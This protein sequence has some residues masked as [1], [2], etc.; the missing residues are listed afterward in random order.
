[1]SEKLQK[2][3]ARVGLG[4]RR[5]MEE[6]IAAG[7]VSVNGQVAQVGERIEPGDELRIDGRK[8]QFQ[9]E[10][11]IRRRVLIYYKPEGEICSRNDPESRPTV[12]DHLPTI[13][14]DRWVMVGRLD[15]N[16]TGLLLFTNDGELA[17]RLMHPSNEIEREYAVR[18][19]GEVTPQIRQ[20]ML[21]GVVLD[22]GPAKFESFTEI[23]G[24]GI[25]RWYQV[26]VKEGRNREVRRIF[27]SQGLK[28]SRLLRTRYGTVILPREL[29]TGRWMELDKADIDNLTKIVELKPRQGTGLFGMAKRRNERMQEKPMAARRGGY[30]RQQRRDNEGENHQHE[31]QGQTQGFNNNYRQERQDNRSERNDNRYDRNDNRGNR[32]DNRSARGENRYDRNERSFDEQRGERSGQRKPFVINK[33]FKKF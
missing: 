19:M 28:V 3:L 22:D 31:G 5:Y 14:N 25:N 26:V 33:G 9:I 11:E 17:N 21:N 6:V 15:I 10:D 16:S 18:V 27:E 7:R 13:A 30:L 4:S 32:N 20:N 12:F 24:E 8:V 29:R 1:M 2:V 23:G